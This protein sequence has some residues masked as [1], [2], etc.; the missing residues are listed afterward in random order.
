MPRQNILPCTNDFLYT[1]FSILFLYT[2]LIVLPNRYLF[3]EIFLEIYQ[4]F[5]KWYSIGILELPSVY[6]KNS[7]IYLK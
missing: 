2:I 4:F 6:A 1:L 5:L 3:K 7:Y